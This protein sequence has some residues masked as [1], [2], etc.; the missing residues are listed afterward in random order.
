MVM[1]IGWN[2]FYKN[3]VRSVVRISSFFIVLVP[4]EVCGDLSPGRCPPGQ[5][6][7]TCSTLIRS[8]PM[9]SASFLLT[10]K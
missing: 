1:S 4:T 9:K 10:A 2:P 5:G 6:I 3:T 7:F 8:A